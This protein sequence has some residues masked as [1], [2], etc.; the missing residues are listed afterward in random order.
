VFVVNMPHAPSYPGVDHATTDAEVT[1]INQLIKGVVNEFTDG[2]VHLFDVD[3]LIGA[4]PDLFYSDGIHFND[5]GEEAVM[6]AAL[7]LLA[8]NYPSG[9]TVGHAKPAG[10]GEA[11]HAL[12]LLDHAS[13]VGKKHSGTILATLVNGS[14]TVT[15]SMLTANTRLAINRVTLGAAPGHLSYTIANAGTDTA[16]FTVTSSSG[17][18]NGQLHIVLVEPAGL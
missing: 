4:N 9:D 14:V 17:T 5:A 11:Q 15:N 3:S 1:T 10:S 7:K 6:K 2:R 13:A 8:A 12:R 18:D 16:S